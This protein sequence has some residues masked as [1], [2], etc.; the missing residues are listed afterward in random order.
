MG[1]RTADDDDLLD[2]ADLK[3]WYHANQTAFRDFGRREF[4]RL[5]AHAA[6]QAIPSNG[7]G[8]LKPT[9]EELVEFVELVL[10]AHDLFKAAFRRK[11]LFNSWARGKEKAACANPLARYMLDVDESWIIY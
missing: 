10:Q 8:R 1:L 7:P 3:T 6:Q 9:A 4:L 11:S 2:R 5:E